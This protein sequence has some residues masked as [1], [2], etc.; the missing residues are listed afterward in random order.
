M[1]EALLL[2]L[3]G[4]RF[5]VFGLFCGLE[6]RVLADSCMT[7]LE[8]FLDVLR[9]DTVSEVSGELLLESKLAVSVTNEPCVDVT[10][11]SS[12]SSSKLSMYSA[13]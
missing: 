10:Y 2:E 8:N 12:S 7:I 1:R 5:P 3:E 13:T 11:R 9:S 6:D 4:L